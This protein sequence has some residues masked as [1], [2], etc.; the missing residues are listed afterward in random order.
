MPEYRET[1]PSVARDAVEV[2]RPGVG[3][4]TAWGRAVRTGAGASARAKAPLPS[5][6]LFFGI[7][8]ELD[9]PFQQLFGRHARKVFEHQLLHVQPNQVSKL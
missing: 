1:T 8:R 3:F 9:R 7:E 4:L 6:E 2:Q 5:F